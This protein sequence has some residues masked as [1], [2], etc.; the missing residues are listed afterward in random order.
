MNIQMP[1]R[2]QKFVDIRWSQRC[3][4]LLWSRVDGVFLTVFP[5][6][7]LWHSRTQSDTQLLWSLYI[8]VSLWCQV[9]FIPPPVRQISWGRFTYWAVFF[10]QSKVAAW[11]LPP[12]DI[13]GGREGGRL[14]PST[15]W[16]L[17]FYKIYNKP[18]VPSLQ[19]CVSLLGKFAFSNELYF[20]RQVNIIITPLI[21]T[22]AAPI[23]RQ[24]WHR[25]AWLIPS[26]SFVITTGPCQ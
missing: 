10:I 16:V 8:I 2:W 17:V 14:I 7:P 6:N 15:L 12:A 20:V 25:T 22:V 13:Q 5:R 19:S 4:G 26:S 1:R 24:G 9:S 3:W 23:S 18:W 11:L 21:T